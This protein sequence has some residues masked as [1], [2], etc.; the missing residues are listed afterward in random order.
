VDGSLPPIPEK[1]RRVGAL[2]GPAE[3]A[4]KDAPYRAALIVGS[5][6]TVPEAGVAIEMPEFGATLPDLGDVVLADKAGKLLPIARFYRQEGRM[7][8]LIAQGLD[9]KLVYYLYFGGG[10]KRETPA[11]QPQMVSLVLETR[12]LMGGTAAF[13]NHGELESAWSAAGN[14]VDGLGFVSGIWH[15]FNPYGESMR[16]VSRYSGWLNTKGM[17]HLT[18]FTQSCDASFVFVNGQYAFGWPGKHK[19]NANMKTVPQKTVAVN[20]P[21]TRIEY[22][23]AKGPE[24][25]DQPTM[26]LGWVIG[27]KYVAIPHEGWVHCGRANITRFEAQDKR[28]VPLANVSYCT[29]IGYNNFWFYE[30]NFW[31]PTPPTDD[32]KVEWHFENGT[33]RTGPLFSR[34]L[35]TNAPQKVTLQLKRGNE[36]LT[37]FRRFQPPDALAASSINKPGDTERYAQALGQDDPAGLTQDELKGYAFFLGQYGTLQQAVRV[38]EAYVRKYKDPLDPV[39]ADSQLVRLRMLAQTNP[40]Q[41]LNDL[42]ALP[43]TGRVAHT[44]RFDQLEAD[45]I[46]FYLRDLTSAGRIEQMAAQCKDRDM[47]QLMRVR[48]GDLYRVNGRNA[49]AIE[50]YRA[51]Q[52]TVTD[53]TGGKKLPAQ[54]EAFAL[55]VSE[56]IEKGQ[57]D[58]AQ[59]NLMEWEVTHPMAKINTSFLVLRGQLLNK[60][61][62]YR[63]ALAELESFKGLNPESPYLVDADF[64]RAQALWELGRKDEARKIGAEIAKKYPK[65]PLAKDSE[66]LSRKP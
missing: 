15:A 3:W 9:P 36:V 41:A 22:Y 60:L 64:Y 18:L 1:F 30:T 63:E 26:V 39:W 45:L 53:A 23:H 59:K 55:S 49:D 38:A 10:K 13:Q 27:G 54:D 62:R 37:G 16:Y 47:S 11:W 46:V 20:G 14:K 32:W 4:V 44:A 43:P 42:R 50:K 6:P 7:A 35:V 33:V 66:E 28:P 48:M 8:L 52:R 17:K 51:A 29:Y 58:E 31:M 12:R 40:Q 57:R 65:H 21:Y 34:V 24:T 61:G 19:A 25:E 2:E 5:A 56:F